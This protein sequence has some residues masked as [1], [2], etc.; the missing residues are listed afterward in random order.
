MTNYYEQYK[1]LVYSI[2]NRF[3]DNTFKYKT[4]I[5]WDEIEQIA[6]IALWKAS[7]MFDDTKGT[8]KNYAITAITRAIYRKIKDDSKIENNSDIDNFYNIE[9]EEKDLDNEIENNKKIKIL[10]DIIDRIDCTQKSKQI[11]KLRVQGYSILEIADMVE[12]ITYQGVY[13][14]IQRHNK[15]IV[16]LFNRRYNNVER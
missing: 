2:V 6:M 3:R 8:F 14:T 7:Q 11:L 5:D 15:N 12:D 13:S 10:Y 4:Y 16:E 9:A 1:R